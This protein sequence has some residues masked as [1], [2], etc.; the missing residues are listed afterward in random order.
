MDQ[1]VFAVDHGK[2]ERESETDGHYHELFSGAP[3]SMWEMDLSGTKEIL[4][5]LQTAG[6]TD[7]RAYFAEH[8]SVVEECARCVQV[9]ELNEAA[10]R[11]CHA[12]SEGEL[13]H[14]L[15][16]MFGSGLPLAFQ[17]CLAT[18]AAG[19]P[20]FEEELALQLPQG[21][22]LIVAV[23]VAILPG[24]E[25]TWKRVLVSMTDITTPRMREDALAQQL[26]EEHTRSTQLHHF[27]HIVA[28]D[29]QNPLSQIVGFAEILEKQHA[30]LSEEELR[31]YLHTVAR[32]GR[33]MSRL[34]KELLALPGFDEDEVAVQPLNMRS[35]VDDVLHSL[36]D[37]IAETEAKIIVPLEWPVALGYAPWV[38]QV[39]A[40]ALSSVLRE[41]GV[42]PQ[43]E[44]GVSSVAAE[45]TSPSRFC[46]WVRT[47][48][49][50][51]SLPEDGQ[52]SDSPTCLTELRVSG[53]GLGL[54]VVRYLVEKMGGE[55][56]IEGKGIPGQGT[57]L[58]FTLPAVTTS[59]YSSLQAVSH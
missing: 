14:N 8:P 30:T 40:S 28:H 2:A 45:D 4:E 27:A 43:V 50:A 51:L 54:P 13:R 32:V 33:R 55:L 12:N 47:R 56:C 29:L 21:S 48:S 57:T 7:L 36:S 38:E 9:V 15:A 3:V 31:K 52:P 18:L 41:G 46:F 22:R 26:L 39:W 24:Y 11:L 42:S 59:P 1:P 44:L 49:A 19:E 5:R 25:R 17:A 37:L 10:V 20:Q 6:V 23:R 58:S 34:I 35:I 53:N 16:A